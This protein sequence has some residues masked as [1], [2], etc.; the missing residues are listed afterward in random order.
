MNSPSTT[1]TLSGG[2]SY[3]GATNISGRNAEP[4][5]L[6]GQPNGHRRQRG[7]AHRL[8]QRFKH[9]RDQRQCRQC[10][11][12]FDFTQ[13]G[14][15]T[16]ATF[17]VGSMNLTTAASPTFSPPPASISPS[18]RRARIRSMAAVPGSPR[19]APPVRRSSMS[20]AP[21]RRPATTSCCLIPH[22]AAPATGT[23]PNAT[24]GVGG[25]LEAGLRSVPGPLRRRCISSW[26]TTYTL[27]DTATQ[28]LL[29]VT[30]TATPAS[31]FWSVTRAPDR[32]PPAP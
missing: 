28:L 23:A 32:S 17:G 26:L 1:L 2:N 3:T 4:H 5:R 7:L 25:T 11:G 15:T 22:K 6:A 14:I 18:A 31:A 24:I 20:P 9:R 27:D 10:G 21:A 12:K 30:G 16:P 13:D 19:S 29:S 8:G